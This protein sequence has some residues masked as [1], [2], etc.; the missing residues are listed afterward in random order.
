MEASKFRV[1]D[2]KEFVKLSIDWNNHEASI[3]PITIPEMFQT[4]V[5]KFGD[6]KALMWREV[7][8]DSWTGIT[9]KEYQ[10]NVI[11]IAKAFIKLGLKR[12]GTVAILSA[13]NA[14]WFIADLAAIHAG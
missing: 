13:N 12:H 10:E 11:K 6:R 5:E 14:E 3:A 9:F 4:T 7:D 1:T 8:N 2:P